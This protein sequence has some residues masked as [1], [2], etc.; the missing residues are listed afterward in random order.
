MP[1]SDPPT[2]HK[3]LEARYGDF[4]IAETAATPE[5]NALKT[6]AGRGS[7]RTFQNKTVPPDLLRLL[8]GVAL[9]SPSKSD[10]QQRDIIEL[11]AP[12]QRRKLCDLIDGQDWI[13]QAPTL[14]IFCGNNRRQRHLHDWHDVPFAND[15]FDAVFNAI[16]DAAIALGAFVTAAEAVGLGCCPISAVRNEAQAVSD[17]LNLPDHVFPMAGLAVGYPSQTPDISMRLPLNITCHVDRYDETGLRDVVQAYDEE[18]RARQP[19][20]KQRFVGAFGETSEYAWSH[21]KTRQYSRPERSNFG[22]FIRR[23]GFDLS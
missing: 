21:D 3:L 16:A 22:A 15:H 4:G 1:Q 18:R 20:T 17:M 9:A 19:Y 2:L 5:Q 12:E 11:R 6:M 23:K 7:C 14:L 13:A 10:L 8:N